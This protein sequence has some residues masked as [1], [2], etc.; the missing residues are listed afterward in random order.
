MVIAPTASGNAYVTGL[1]YSMNFPVTVGP[2]LT[3][4][5]NYNAFVVKIGA[6]I[7]LEGSVAVGALRS[8]GRKSF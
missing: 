3:Y 1:T 8:S 5:G 7:D 6:L 2:D 4:N